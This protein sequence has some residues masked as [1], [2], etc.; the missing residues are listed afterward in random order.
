MRRDLRARRRALPRWRQ[1]R[2]ARRLAQL[3][4]R[5]RWYRRARTLAAYIANDGEIDPAPLLRAAR[6]AGKRVLLPRLRGRRLEFVGWRGAAALRR[7]R[8][9]IPEPVGAA[10]ALARIDVV[11]LPLVGF[12]RSGGRLGMGGGFYDR[13]F[14][15]LVRKNRNGARGPR[16]IGCG[17]AFQEVARLPHEAWDVHLTGVVTERECLRFR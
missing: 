12:D 7:N 2:A 10:T 5:Q 6:A 9:D 17:Y 14:A 8:F 1:R 16:L 13:T 3:A 4:Q 11:C 15:A